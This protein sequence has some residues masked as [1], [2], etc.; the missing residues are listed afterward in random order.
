VKEDGLINWLKQHS[1]AIGIGIILIATN[2]GVNNHRL[3]QVEEDLTAFEI[4]LIEIEADV[5]TIQLDRA[6]D[7]GAIKE[8]LKN[9]ER[10]QE[11]FSE[12]FKEQ[13]ERIR[14]FYERY[15]AVL[16]PDGN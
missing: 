6:R 7:M 10:T 15:G 12:A 14:I 5:E 3:N 11:D 1:Y 16:N 2:Y 8:S 4:R 13:T 9:I